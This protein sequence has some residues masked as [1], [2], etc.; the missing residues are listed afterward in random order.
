MQCKLSN[1]WSLSQ[2]LMQVLGEQNSALSFGEEERKCSVLM[3][4]SSNCVR[5]L[6]DSFILRKTSL[7]SAQIYLLISPHSSA[8]VHTKSEK[9]FCIWQ[10]DKECVYEWV[11]V[12]VSVCVSLCVQNLY[13][14][15]EIRRHQQPLLLPVSGEKAGDTRCLFISGWSHL[16]QCW[17]LVQ[18]LVPSVCTEARWQL[19]L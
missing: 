17:H 16:R 18:H 10:M 12:I 4:S 7:R 3:V 2:A 19:S 9:N 8:K 5:R 11:H 6:S 15:F 14:T 13:R 1:S